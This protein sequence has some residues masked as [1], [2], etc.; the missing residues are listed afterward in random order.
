MITFT[1]NQSLVERLTSCFLLIDGRVMTL[2]VI[3]HSSASFCMLYYVAQSPA[4]HADL[5]MCDSV[6][7]CLF[8]LNSFKWILHPPTTK[9]EVNA[10]SKSRTI[11]RKYYSS[12]YLG[13]S[14]SSKCFSLSQRNLLWERWNEL[15]QNRVPARGHARYTQSWHLNHSNHP[16]HSLYNNILEREKE[17]PATFMTPTSQRP[18]QSVTTCKQTATHTHWH[19]THTEWLSSHAM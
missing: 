10:S 17:S 19:G 8:T 14:N 11:S 18:T 5:T 13:R 6:I 16:S 9:T 2:I 3:I 7:H 1:C 15:K 4:S 12:T